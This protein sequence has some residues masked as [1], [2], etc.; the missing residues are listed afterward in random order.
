MG[1]RVSPRHADKRGAVLAEFVLAFPVLLLTYLC[2]LQMAQAYTAGLVMRHAAAVVARYASVS[3]PNRFIPDKADR[4]NGGTNPT[5]T[6]AARGALGPWRNV[7]RVKGAVVDFAGNDPWGDVVVKVDF[8]YSCHVQIAN[9]IVCRDGLM[10]R[11]I[12]VATPLQGGTYT[13]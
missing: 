2:C 5:W 11:T 4:Q 1:V 3:Y 7:V 6:E 13:L 9:L 12:H 10:T 8:E